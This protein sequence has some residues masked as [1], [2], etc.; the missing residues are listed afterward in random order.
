MSEYLGDE[1]NS[2]TGQFDKYFVIGPNDIEN[3]AYEPQVDGEGNPLLSD[4]AE[5]LKLQKHTDIR[6]IEPKTP[7]VLATMLHMTALFD[8]QT[9][10]DMMMD[11]LLSL[12]LVSVGETWSKGSISKDPA[13]NNWPVLTLTCPAGE[14]TTLQSF[15]RR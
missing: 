6:S 12:Y 2:N 3:G 8:M 5:Q 4:Q 11:E 13:R 15:L 7:S 9:M 1:F 10:Q 14:E